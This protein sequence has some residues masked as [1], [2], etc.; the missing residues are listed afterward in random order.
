MIEVE[1]YWLMANYS[2]GEASWYWQALYNHA[3]I[4]SDP[5]LWCNH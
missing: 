2:H 5:K 1:F 3:A 4:N